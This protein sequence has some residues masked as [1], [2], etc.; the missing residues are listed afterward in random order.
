MTSCFLETDVEVHEQ[1]IPTFLQL[2]RFGDLI[3]LGP[4]FKHWADKVGAAVNV[5]TS[6]QFGSVLDGMS[7]V[8]KIEAD[9][10]WHHDAGKILNE[11]KR[12]F[13]NLYRTQLHGAGWTTPPDSLPSYSI[14]M[15]ARA[16]LTLEDYK[17]LPLVFDRRNPEREQKLIQTWRKTDKPL[18]LLCLLGHTSPL[19]A[20]AAI[21]KAL[22]PFFNRCE[23]LNLNHNEVR[24]QRVYDLLGLMDI[25][26]GLITLDSMP[27]HLSAASKVPVI[28]Y[29]RD[30]C[31]AGSIPKNN[32]HLTIGYSKAYERLPDLVRTVE[33][34]LK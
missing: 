8:N 31:Q 21:I 19:K 6:K 12:H 17:R 33:G 30:D 11:A 18:I 20:E 5:V 14:S 32:N 4:A 16:G 29:V 26:A 2:G 9:G 13:P 28:N 1:E 27:L 3:L 22:A 7:Y 24:A 25:A 34:W 15:W 23:V 10:D